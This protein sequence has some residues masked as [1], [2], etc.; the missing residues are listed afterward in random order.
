MHIADC[1]LL[2]SLRL[3]VSEVIQAI[4]NQL[5]KQ[6]DLQKKKVWFPIF[7]SI[8]IILSH[9]LYTIKYVLHSPLQ[10]SVAVMLNM[11]FNYY[12]PLLVFR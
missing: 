5:S 4:D 3:C 6:E 9:F 2:Q 8:D 11:F 1:C 12:I 7:L 10:S